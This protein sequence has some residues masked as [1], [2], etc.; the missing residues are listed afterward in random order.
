VLARGELHFTPDGVSRPPA[1]V[2]TNIALLAEGYP[3][4][5]QST[6]RTKLL[7]YDTALAAVLR[8]CHQGGSYSERR[9]SSLRI[10]VTTADWTVY[11]THQQPYLL[12]AGGG[13][14][15]EHV[16]ALLLMFLSVICT[17]NPPPNFWMKAVPDPTP[18][19]ADVSPWMCTLRVPFVW[20]IWKLHPC[21]TNVPVPLAIGTPF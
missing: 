13:T 20:S 3:Q 15:G 1:H 2:T 21:A 4:A 18:L 10:S 17:T 14:P 11:G 5:R 19:F 12:G 9:L 7:G 8:N 16:Q 6:V